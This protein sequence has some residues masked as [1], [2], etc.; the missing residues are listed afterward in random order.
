MANQVGEINVKIGADTA[1]LNSGVDDAEKKLSKFD[2]AVSKTSTSVKTSFGTMAKAAAAFAAVYA[3]A[4]SSMKSI[5]MADEFNLLETRVRTATKAT[6][7]FNTVF[8]TLTSNA[9]ASGASLEATVSA[10][11]TISSSGRD[12]GKTN[13]DAIQFVDT[14]QK[15]GAIG[16]AS[17]EAMKNSLTQMSQSMAGGIVRA[18]EFNSI[19]ENTPEVARAMADSL[20]MS[21]GELR[22]MVLEGRLMASDVFDA[23][24][25][26]SEEVNNTFSEMP[27][28]LG[29]SSESATTAFGLMFSAID[30]S[31]QVTQFLSETLDK[32][33]GQATE[34]S[35]RLSDDAMTEKAWELVD[36]Q[37]TLNKLVQ[38]NSGR[39]IARIRHLREQIALTQE[40]MS[41]I[42]SANRV[43]AE[44]DKRAADRVAKKELADNQ[45]AK[46]LE[47]KLWKENAVLDAQ[48]DSIEAQFKGIEAG[49]KAAES[50]QARNNE[51]AAREEEELANQAKKLELLQQEYQWQEDLAQ[52]TGQGTAE[53]QAFKD[54][55]GT[56]A[57]LEKLQ[58]LYMSENELLI[59][60]YEEQQ[61]IIDE[62][63]M[64]EQISTEEHEQ[65]LLDIHAKYTNEKIKLD[66]KAH[67]IED[68]M[69]KSALGN[70]VGFL[71][72][73]SSESKAAAIAS[74]A[75]TKGLAIAE[76]I[77][78][79]QTASMHA[80]A[81]LGPI[82]GPP[83]VAGIQSMGSLS[84]GLIA[85]TGL[86]QA[87]SVM[88]GG[89]SSASGVTSAVNS[90]SSQ[91]STSPSALSSPT[92]GTLT[93]EGLSASSLFTGD[94][95]A[96]IATELLDYQREG[97][98]VV[99]QS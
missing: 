84:V 12:L 76:T 73:L 2:S 41:G 90:N 86:L 49:N 10:F 50:E 78:H 27:K 33:A 67:A 29:R 52:F 34:I 28:T 31:Y 30:E 93:V 96:A 56:Q 15:L 32:I 85:A 23:I 65:T 98:Q 7:D 5:K 42:A 22:M 8:S 6:G 88:S 24:L 35:S 19:I 13:K 97:G 20:G 45:E 70:A 55:E 21:V 69:R 9:M 79:T 48:L 58:D 53:D 57:K 87:G 1:G 25:N 51:K 92:G 99:L 26:K 40:Q 59:A 83:A 60:K 4:A 37:R 82:A 61:L 74:I 47:N 80:M 94:A 91:T 54:E 71:N 66:E 63:Y 38:L 3:A 36:A 75:L 77:A 46:A 81:Q 39:D 95:V 18:E 89:S 44:M 43:F 16:G 62:A 14:F 72:A 64:N 11:Q 68:S 17:T